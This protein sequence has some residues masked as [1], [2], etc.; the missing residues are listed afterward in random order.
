MTSAT[1]KFK[2]KVVKTAKTIVL[3]SVAVASNISSAYSKANKDD[4]LP[5]KDEIENFNK[6]ENT[7]PETELVVDYNGN[8]FRYAKDNKNPRYEKCCPNL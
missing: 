4:Y 5:H 7:T 3:A 8:E 2:D 6:M 1:K